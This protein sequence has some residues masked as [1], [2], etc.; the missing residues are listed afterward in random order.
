M[1]FNF[2]FVNVLFLFGGL[3][4]VTIGLSVLGGVDVI[5]GGSII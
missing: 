4:V 5:T 2:S 3:D 1:H